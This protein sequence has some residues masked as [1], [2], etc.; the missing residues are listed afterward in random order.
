[1]KTKTLKLVGAV[2]T[3]LLLQNLSACGGGDGSS[4]EPE[5]SDAVLTAE[6]S[7]RLASN[8]ADALPGCSYIS[9]DGASDVSIPSSKV[10]QKVIEDLRE[11]VATPNTSQKMTVSS[12]PVEEFYEGSCTVPGSL[13]VTGEHENG[14]DDL[15]YT[16]DNYC[17]GDDDDSV[18]LIGTVDV[19]NDG[20]PSDSGP[21][22]QATELSTNEGGLQIIESGTE[23]TFTHIVELDDLVYNF[24]NGDEGSTADLPSSFSADYVRIVDG[25]SGETFSVSDVNIS[26]YNADESDES[27]RVVNLI[28]I[29]YTDPENGAVTV[30][31]TENLVISSDGVMMD[32][33][34]EVT[35]EGDGASLTLV[36]SATLE[37]SFD[38]VLDS[39]GGS[40]DVGV[41]DCSGLVGGTITDSF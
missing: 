6:T 39:E 30:S 25:R 22:P 12:R 20:E 27:D 40:E 38:L 31:S 14:D 24:G 23:G 34:L 37:N 15:V 2:A 16:F 36:P 32:G 41:M 4:S 5:P 18:T 9:N 1:M 33:S 21:I 35:A 26:T 8:A 19:D 3:G 13:T 17:L 28:S 11:I 7:E 10:A 29:T